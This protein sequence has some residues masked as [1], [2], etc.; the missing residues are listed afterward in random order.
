[1]MRL[2]DAAA[3]TATLLVGVAGTLLALAAFVAIVIW[4]WR[5]SRSEIERWARQ[6]L[7]DDSW[8]RP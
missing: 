3:G 5:R 2:S 4:T 8:T 1:M 6:P 7:E